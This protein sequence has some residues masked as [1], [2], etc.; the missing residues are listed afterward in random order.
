MTVDVEGIGLCAPCQPAEQHTVVAGVLRDIG[1]PTVPVRAGQYVLGVRVNSEDAATVLHEVFADRVVVGADP[2]GN[3][4]LWLSPDSTDGVQELHRLFW[5][6]SSV[7]RTLSVRRA[8]AALWHHF[9]AADARSV[10]HSPLVDATV[11][12]AEEAAHLLPP[13]WRELVV[14]HERHWTREGFRL[15]DRPWHAVDFGSARI[16]VQQPVYTEEQ[17]AALLRLIDGSHV[18]DR[19]VPLV[20]PGSLKIESWTLTARETTAA[21]RVLLAAKQ[22][23]NLV[24]HGAPLVRQL[25]DLMSTVPQAPVGWGSPD[26]LPGLLREL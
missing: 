22:V 24:D 10:G 5:N 19:D 15:V 25:V 16:A 17:N 8:I 14:K 4:S 7:L 11:L 1:L 3:L 20:A 6:C 21:T 18:A 2:P 23:L 12:V 26:Q 13:H 9:E